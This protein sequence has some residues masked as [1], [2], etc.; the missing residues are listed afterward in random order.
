MTAK[1]TYSVDALT[2]LEVQ[3]LATAW[4][5]PK[6]EV[7]R[8]AVHAASQQRDA[9][10]RRPMTAAE[11]LDELQKAP[12]LSAAEAKRWTRAVRDERQASHRP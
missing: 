6:S 10:G 3:E 9:L 1:V 2:V 8:L 4:G 7:I 11:A 5:V 12:R